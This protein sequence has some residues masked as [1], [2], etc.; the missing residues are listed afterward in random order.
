MFNLV[1]LL[2]ASLVVGLG[3]IIYIVDFF[4]PFLLHREYRN[5]M[6]K[7]YENDF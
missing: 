6:R 5:L 3:L 4:K 2:V 1:N 7:L